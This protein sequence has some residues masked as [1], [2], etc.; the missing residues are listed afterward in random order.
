MLPDYLELLH[1]Q[2]HLVIAL[3]IPGILCLTHFL[4]QAIVL[5]VDHS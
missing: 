3:I 4:K 5:L 1:L 2:I